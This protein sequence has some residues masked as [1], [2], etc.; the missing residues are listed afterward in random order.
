MLSLGNLPVSNVDLAI[1]GAYAAMLLV[2]KNASASFILTCLYFSIHATPYRSFHCYM[3]CS[4][5]YFTVSIA[6]IRISIEIRQA[7]VCFGVIYL[8]SAIDNFISYHFDYDTQMDLALKPAV[9]VLNAYV[10]SHLFGDWRRN[11][12]DGFAHYCARHL[13]RCKIR[14]LHHSQ[15]PEV[16]K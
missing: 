4:M 6:N 15:L 9:I 7:F 8:L 12:V 10:L 5:L 13:R 3:L 2:N 1:F 14:P 16:K 11:N